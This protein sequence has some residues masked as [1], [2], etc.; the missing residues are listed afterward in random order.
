MSKTG[1]KE[2]SNN[3]RRPTNVLII[4]DYPNILQKKE[5]Q[6]NIHNAEEHVESEEKDEGRPESTIK[7]MRRVV[8]VE[9]P[10][11]GY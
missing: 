7:E 6:R 4:E 9:Y 5:P 2:K 1:G 3:N 11:P 10:I 8:H